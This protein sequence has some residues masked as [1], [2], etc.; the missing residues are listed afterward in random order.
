[1]PSSLRDGDD[2]ISSPL[3]SPSALIPSSSL[4]FFTTSSL[5]NCFVFSHFVKSVPTEQSESCTISY[6]NVFH[7]KHQ[8][9]SLLHLNILCFGIVSLWQYKR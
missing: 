2:G 5:F 9:L 1:M 8:Q 6:D 7:S 3:S 4:D